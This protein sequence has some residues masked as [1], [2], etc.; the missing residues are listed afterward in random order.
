MSEQLN[1][2]RQ[3]A[4]DQAA[5]DEVNEKLNKLPAA[6]DI[7][8]ADQTAV[9]E[10]RN[11]YDALEDIKEGLKDRVPAEARAKMTAAE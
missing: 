6:K 5:V 1:I 4:A 11:A 8:F 9:T 7:L 10:A 2:L 3:E